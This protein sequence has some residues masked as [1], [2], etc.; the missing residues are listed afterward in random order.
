MAAAPSVD[1]QRLFCA[2]MITLALASL[3]VAVST[4]WAG[5]QLVHAGK[6]LVGQRNEVIFQRYTIVRF[7]P[8]LS[9][10]TQG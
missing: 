2:E 5:K 6:G 10:H 3:L 7:P 8:S 4:L 9:L 1:I